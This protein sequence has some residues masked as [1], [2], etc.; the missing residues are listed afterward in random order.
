MTAYMFQFELPAT[1]SEEMNAL[2]PLQRSH[3]EQLFL[4]GRLLSYS[5]SQL[6][7]AAWCV[8]AAENEQAAMELVA[9]FP[10]HPYFTDT[11]CHPLLFHNT[12]PATLPEFSRN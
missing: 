1:Y 2:I 6:R 8:V 4:E 5:V 9:G 10:M 12:I 7:S 11:M 3:V